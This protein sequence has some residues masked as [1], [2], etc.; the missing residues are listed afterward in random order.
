MV[1]LFSQPVLCCARHGTRQVLQPS[2]YVLSLPLADLPCL[3]LTHCLPEQEQDSD[4]GPPAQKQCSRGG[5]KEHGSHLDKGWEKA[6]TTTV[7]LYYSLLKKFADKTQQHT[8]VVRQLVQRFKLPL[9]FSF[10]CR[11]IERVVS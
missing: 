2:R 4:A 1:S 6:T 10:S 3:F 8:E 5:R 7:A 9:L 11:P